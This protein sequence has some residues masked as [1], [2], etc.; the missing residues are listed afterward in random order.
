LAQFFNK[1]F[2]I[3]F[4]PSSHTGA[5]GITV[6]KHTLKRL[7]SNDTATSYRSEG[8]HMLYTCPFAGCGKTLTKKSNM[9]SPKSIMIIKCSQ[10]AHCID[11]KI[12]L[13]S[14]TGQLSLRV[15]SQFQFKSSFYIQIR[16][17]KKFLRFFFDFFSFK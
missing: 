10:H 7:I 15:K 11:T 12:D 9:D 2:I 8:L 17:R 1:Q 3:I 16:L 6:I 14:H 4:S 5:S 13:P